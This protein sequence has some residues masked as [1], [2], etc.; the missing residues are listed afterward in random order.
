MTMP[1]TDI[2]LNML[3]D[4]AVKAAE[5]LKVDPTPIALY[6]IFKDWRDKAKEEGKT[7]YSISL[8]ELLMINQLKRE[9]AEAGL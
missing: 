3:E 1:S 4:E 2:A 5:K 7:A 9:V 8:L 6:L